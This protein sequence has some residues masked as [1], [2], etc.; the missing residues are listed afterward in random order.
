MVLQIYREKNYIVTLK[1]TS[2]FFFR[3]DFNLFFRVSFVML[4]HL[5]KIYIKKFI[6]YRIK[7]HLFVLHLALR[8]TVFHQEWYNQK[9]YFRLVGLLVTLQWLNGIVQ[10]IDKYILCVLFFD[11]LSMPLGLGG[12]LYEDQGKY[13]TAPAF[14]VDLSPVDPT[15]ATANNS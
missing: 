14:A 6:S 12:R 2:V 7:L 3:W 5:L 13:A 8:Q 1:F 9:Y 11:C 4:P 15:I 10:Y